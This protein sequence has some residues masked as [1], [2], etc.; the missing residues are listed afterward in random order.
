[1]AKRIPTPR[2]TLARLFTVLLDAGEIRRLVAYT[3]EGLDRDL[4]GESRTDLADA[5]ADLLLRRGLVDDALFERLRELAPGRKAAIRQAQV[6]CL[7]PVAPGQEAPTIMTPA[8]TP[9]PPPDAPLR[10]FISY[11]AQDLVEHAKAAVA[12]VRRLEWVAVDHRDWSA[13]G[14]PSLD[15]CREKVRSCQVLVVLVAHRYGWVP[16]RDEGGDGERSVTWLEVEEARAHGIEVLPF[17]VDEDTPWPPKLTDFRDPVAMDR[18][19]RFKEILSQNIRASFTTPESVEALVYQALADLRERH[20]ASPQPPPVPT[21]GAADLRTTYRRRVEEQHR[22]IELLGLGDQLHV[23][24]PID[25]AYVTLR[26]TLPMALERVPNPGKHRSDAFEGC[27]EVERDVSLPE[28]FYKAAEHDRIGVA[29]LGDPGCGKTTAAQHIAW[30]C[31]DPTQGP[32]SLG[33]PAGMVPVLLRLRRLRDLSQ[34]LEGF[35]VQELGNVH[36]SDQADLGH[37]LYRGGRLLWILDGLDEVAD[38]KTRA[39]VSRWIDEAARVRPDDR[40]LVTCRYAGWRG[41]AVLGPAFQELH[42][43]PL[44]QGQR[45]EF[46]GRWFRAVERQV[47]GATPAAEA[48]AVERTAALTELLETGDFRVQAGLA[49]L[50]ANPLILSILCVVYRKE[51]DLPRR[52]ALLYARCVDVLLHHWRTAKDMPGLSVDAARAVL[53]PLA[54]WMHGEE[55]RTEAPAAPLV[56]RIDPLLASMGKDAPAAGGAEFLERTCDQSGLMV[57]PSPG[58]FGFLHLSFQEYL[59]AAHASHR[60]G[61]AR[62]L[63][64]RFGQSWWNET[65]LLALGQGSEDFSQ[66]FFQAVLR[67]KAPDPELLRLCLDDALFAPLEPFL[68]ALGG[69]PERQALVLRLLVG[70]KD[71]RLVEVV[72]PLA[73]SADAEVAAVAR[74]LLLRAGVEPPEDNERLDER[75][76]IVLVRVPAGRFVMGS[77]DDEE[78]RSEDERPRHEVTISRDLWMGKHPVT[79]EQYARFLAA[80]TE[81]SKPGSWDDRRFNQPRQP[82]VGVS[83]HDALAYCRWASRPGRPVRLPLEAEWEHAC[84]AGTST[85]FWSGD[86]DED[87]ARV[88]WFW[89]N[90]GGST[91]PVGEKPANP[92]G[93]CDLHGNV[94]EWCH[95]ERLPYGPEAR[96]VDPAAVPADPG[97]AVRVVRGGCWWIYPRW[98]R[99]AFRDRL[100]PVD[101]NVFVGFRVVLPPAPSRL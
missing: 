55:N 82:V 26:A 56:E 98:C 96:T 80:K 18:L 10:V 99:S 63:A 58:R 38:A 88:G 31:A 74:E 27:D 84:R 23:R 67:K 77:P 5:A 39:R 90:S 57:R 47:L 13:V 33:L 7:A 76:G 46:V 73:R 71:P 36:L 19:T 22:C 16:S 42:V 81:H 4:G 40:F 14:R 100:H 51:L 34:G 44:D 20:R 37:Q 85:R 60:T 75:T 70:R 53:Q 12:A 89:G 43:Q 41:D 11:T 25:E 1:M 6:H 66:A 2:E 54:W 9:A 79:N 21:G 72:R 50:V 52:R 48:R 97:G 45:A 91:H 69:P 93:L 83:W 87:L 28:V 3:A 94:W 92:W 86:G 15:W 64:A 17:L 49:A 65:T 59:A 62:F 78:G 24:L 35:L 101:R 68:G 30:R 95:D 61:E 32:E 29:L 8:A